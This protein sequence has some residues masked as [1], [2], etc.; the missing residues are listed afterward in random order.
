[1]DPNT[2]ETRKARVKRTFPTP[3][4]A[5]SN[6]GGN[7]DAGAQRLWL[8]DRYDAQ[9]RHF[10]GKSNGQGYRPRFHDANYNGFS[11]EAL[12]LSVNDRRL[13][14]ERPVDLND[15]QVLY[16]LKAFV[17]ELALESEADELALL[18]RLVREIDRGSKAPLSKEKYNKLISQFLC[19][20]NVQL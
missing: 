8:Q 10:H 15:S 2:A 4:S 17:A 9:R 20:A 13:E 7:K 18:I 1:M 6:G 14:L 11:R 3:P 12:A 19:Q 5:L 16:R